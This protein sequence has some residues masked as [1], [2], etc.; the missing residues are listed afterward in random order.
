MELVAPEGPVYQAGTLSGNP[1]A[2]RAGLETLKQLRRP[3][4]Y[5]QLEDRAAQLEAGLRRTLEA[6]NLPYYLTRVGSMGCL[7]FT[8]RPVKN[9]TDALRC[10]TQAYGRFF[11]GM[12]AEGIYLAPSQF[13]AF[14]LSAAHSREDVEHT[15]AAA[16][17]VLA[18]LAEASRP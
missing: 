18:Q 17:R 13:E 16:G 9:Y 10:D 5:Q 6:L 2:M 12:L 14:F 11:H 1:L 3:G 4:F 7:F 8:D 15:V